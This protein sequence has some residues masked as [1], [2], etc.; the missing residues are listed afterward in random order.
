MTINHPRLA[1]QLDTLAG[2]APLVRCFARSSDH[3]S[4]DPAEQT[5]FF[6]PAAGLDG[7]IYDQ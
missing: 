5:V 3:T 1:F 2:F 7:L 4:T 6:K